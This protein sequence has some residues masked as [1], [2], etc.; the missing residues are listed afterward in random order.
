MLRTSHKATCAAND[1]RVSEGIIGMFLAEG[2]CGV[3][4]PAK[5]GKSGGKSLAEGDGIVSTFWLTKSLLF[6]G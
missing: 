3:D 2:T 5:I 1:N 6:L 4:A